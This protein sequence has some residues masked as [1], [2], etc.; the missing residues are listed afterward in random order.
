MPRSGGPGCDPWKKR[1]KERVRQVKHLPHRP[2]GEGEW[3]GKGIT[4]GERET[5][6]LEAAPCNTLVKVGRHDTT[7]SSMDNFREK[8]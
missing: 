2:A 1:M 7:I 3:E 5:L 4:E 8:T 6:S